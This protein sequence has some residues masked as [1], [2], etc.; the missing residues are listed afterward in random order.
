MGTQTSVNAHA[1]PEGTRSRGPGPGPGPGCSGR[2]DG[3]AL[4]NDGRWTSEA[5]TLNVFM[6]SPGSQNT[7]YVSD[8]YLGYK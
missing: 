8:H 5:K 1:L 3:A 2:T 7:V 6:N 4:V